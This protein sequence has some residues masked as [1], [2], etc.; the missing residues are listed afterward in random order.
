MHTV[1]HDVA[2]ALAKVIFY[3]DHEFESNSVHMRSMGSR[4]LLEGYCR[5]LLGVQDAIGIGT[6]Y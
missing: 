1:E 3:V 4:P 5:I 2:Q 6:Y